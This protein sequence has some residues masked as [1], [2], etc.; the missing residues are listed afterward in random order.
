MRGFSGTRRADSDSPPGWDLR[1]RTTASALVNEL[2]E[3]R[4]EMRLLNL[5]KRLA[6]LK[7]L[8]I[9]NSASC[10]AVQDRGGARGLGATARLD[11]LCNLQYRDRSSCGLCSGVTALNGEY[12]SSTMFLPDASI[13]FAALT[14]SLTVD[15]ALH[16]YDNL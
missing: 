9:A 6:R 7:L 11:P 16:R 8:I 14:P 12:L 4:D 1:Q 2:M 13:D 10:R 3:A 5:Q 15:S